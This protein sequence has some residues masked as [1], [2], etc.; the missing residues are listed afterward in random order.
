MKSIYTGIFKTGR[1]Y[2]S[3]V[4]SPKILFCYTGR[5]ANLDEYHIDIAGSDKGKT[6]HHCGSSIIRSETRVE[7]IIKYAFWTF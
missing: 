1:G 6:T 3:T 5:K 7:L 2:S 4:P